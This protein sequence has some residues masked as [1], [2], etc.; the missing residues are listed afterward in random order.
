MK[1]L[2]V[3]PT[4]VLGG[5]ERVLLS[6]LAALRQARPEVQ[7]HLLALSDGPLLDSAAELG[8]ETT[9]LKAPAGLRMFGEGRFCQSNNR[10]LRAASML[11]KS[12]PLSL[13]IWAYV[14]R[15]RRFVREISP[16][17]IHSNGIKTH[18]LL[19]LTGIRSI[20]VWWH[21]HDFLS[22]R[23]LARR[24][25]GWAVGRAAGAIAISNAV[26]QDLRRLWPTLDVQVIA[27]A[28]DADRFC[29]GWTAPALLDRLAG[30]ASLSCLRVG[31]V[32]AYARW[33]GHDVFLAAAARLMRD[34]PDIPVRFYI[35]GGPIYETHGSQWSRLELDAIARQLGVRDRVGFIDFQMDILP[36]YRALDVVVHAS[37]APEPFGLTII[38]AMACGKPVI[39]AQAGG[40]AEI[41]RPQHDA[42][43]TAPGDDRALASALSVL[44]LDQAMRDRLGRNARRTA[45]E[46][47]DH[48][49][50]AAEIV[51]LV[52]S[53][54]DPNE[55]FMPNNRNLHGSLKSLR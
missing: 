40:A 46:R 53:V 28:V 18:M 1:V 12:I 13:S 51:T 43:A 35:V 54:N 41:I 24:I 36:I 47:F 20:P 49:R 21:V 50:F 23:P 6:V 9:V 16:D 4:G 37:T 8:V 17:L 11:T 2:F 26:G 27:N 3:S 7:C 14:R 25:L 31:L 34:F 22:Q 10:I 32:A 29:P 55:S 52:D 19:W 48:R 15:L 38:E 39:V 42:L 33:K 44:L 45:C 30:L 5:A